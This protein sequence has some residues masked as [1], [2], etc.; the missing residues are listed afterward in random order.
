MCMCLPIRNSSRGYTMLE[1]L[2]V[3]TLTIM[4]AGAGFAAF[5]SYSQHQLV[6]QE[7]ENVKSAFDKA[8][9]DAISQVKPAVCTGTLGG[10]SVLITNSIQYEISAVCVSGG[11]ANNII[12]ETDTLTSPVVFSSDALNCSGL[13]YNTVSNTVTL[14][15]TTECSTITVSANGISKQLNVDQTS[16]IVS[17]Q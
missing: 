7:A 5:S 3:F 1:L 12:V 14:P 17:I 6:S 16:G 11:A 13:Q 9:F 15:S 10:Y 8:R 2:V 4:I